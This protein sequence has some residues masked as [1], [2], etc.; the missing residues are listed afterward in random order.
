[1]S[2]TP[3]PEPA[4]L[5]TGWQIIALVG[6]VLGFLVGGLLLVDPAERTDLMRSVGST[7]APHAGTILA[8]VAAMVAAAAARATRHE[9]ARQTPMIETAVRNTNG[10]LTARDERIRELEAQLEAGH[11]RERVT[12][13]DPTDH[14]AGAPVTFV[15]V[16]TPPPVSQ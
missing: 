10:A 9:T 13:P 6:L 15:N 5:L 14:D 7:V 16:V 8:A 1:M 2:T 12:T 4:R 11:A 3:A